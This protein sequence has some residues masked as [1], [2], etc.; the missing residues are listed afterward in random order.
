MRKQNVG[1]WILG[2]MMAP[3]R[4]GAIVGDLEQNDVGGVGFWMAIG[5]SVLHAINADVLGV[6]AKG[7]L[8]QF[9]LALLLA[10][11][12][13]FPFLLRTGPW[14]WTSAPVILGIQILTGVWLGRQTDKR[15]LVT[16]MLIVAADCV[17]GLL[18][19]NNAS[20]NMS[21]W[22]IPLVATTVAIGRTHRRKSIA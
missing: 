5:S 13:F 1:E 21:I 11:V 17:L 6:A 15:P 3:E 14:P 12:R 10:P 8:L 22:S 20:I 7:F 16:C 18:R 9:L 19:F 4:A 2:Q